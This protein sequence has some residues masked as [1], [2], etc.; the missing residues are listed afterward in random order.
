[1]TLNTQKD[2]ERKPV[3]NK[4]GYGIDFTVETYAAIIKDLQDSIKGST[5]EVMII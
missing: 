3:Q 2:L 5:L 4:K 1:M